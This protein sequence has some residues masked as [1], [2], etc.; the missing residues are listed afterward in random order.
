MRS[1]GWQILMARL[2]HLQHHHK[3]K[4][5]NETSERLAGKIQGYQEIFDELDY[6]VK[7]AVR[8]NT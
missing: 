3:D 1:Q 7:K 6:I 2:N 4:L 8:E 5:V